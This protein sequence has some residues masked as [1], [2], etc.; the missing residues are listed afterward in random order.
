MT[1]IKCNDCQKEISITA[2]SCP[3]CG[4]KKPFKNVTLSPEESKGLSYKEKRSFQKRGGKILLS[5][6]QKFTLIIIILVVVFSVSKCS[7]DTHQA[8]RN[9]AN[10]DKAIHQLNDA[11]KDP[12]KVRLLECEGI[13]PWKT[14]PDDWT[15]PTKAECEQINRELDAET[16][17]GK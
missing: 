2:T 15:P 17:A 12:R 11:L 9:S 7:S 8:T 10:L 13:N 14:K 6:V 4:S 1:L 5:K 3:N 16:K